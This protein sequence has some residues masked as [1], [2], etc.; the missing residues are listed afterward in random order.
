MN[1]MTMVPLLLI[2][3]TSDNHQVSG[4]SPSYAFLYS[5]A[6]LPIIS[7]AKLPSGLQ[8][9]EPIIGTKNPLPK[10]RQGDITTVHF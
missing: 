4:E 9:T 8:L 10:L 5:L 2:S 6:V 7:A 3:I 1:G